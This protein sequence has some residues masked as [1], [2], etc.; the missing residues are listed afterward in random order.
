MITTGL[1]TPSGYACH[2]S[3]GGELIADESLFTVPLPWRGA[4]EG[5]GG[6]PL[7]DRDA[8]YLLIGMILIYKP[9]LTAI[10][11]SH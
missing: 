8:P 7:S 2:P 6:E 5:R 9:T 10:P 11:T 3:K 1:T 4:P